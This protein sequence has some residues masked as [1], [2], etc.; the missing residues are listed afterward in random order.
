M[1]STKRIKEKKENRERL[2]L[3][4]ALLIALLSTVYW[5]AITT[6]AYRTFQ[7]GNND[8]A[9]YA[10]NFYFY[11]HYSSIPAPLQ[12]LVFS[13]HISPDMLIVMLLFYLHQSALTLLYI[14]V[15]LICLS[16]LLVFQISRKLIGYSSIALAFFLAFLINPG[17]LGILT[18]SFHVE[19]LLI[20]AYLL[21]FYFYMI[22]NRK[23]FIV[24]LLFL[25][26]TMEVAPILSLTLGLGLLAYEL[27][28]S[29]HKWSKI[30][31]KKRS[32]LIMLI[33]ISIIAGLLYYGAIKYLISSY[34]NS[35]LLPAP[36]QISSGSEISLLSNLHSVITNPIKLLIGNLSVYTN[37]V[38]FYILILSALIV[39]FGF[40][41]FTLKKWKV[42]LLLLLPWF[43]ALLTWHAS[44]HF[45]Y[46]GYQYYSYSLGATV[47]ASIIGIMSVSFKS[48]KKIIIPNFQRIIVILS[49]L[50]IAVLL[51]ESSLIIAPAPLN[52]LINYNNPQPLPLYNASQIDPLINMIPQNASLMVQDFI[53]PHL[54]ERKYIEYTW[55]IETNGSYFIPDYILV[56]Y[57][58]GTNISKNGTLDFFSR[59]IQ[60]YNYTLYARDGNARLYK[61][62]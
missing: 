44:L 51:L 48:A 15:I 4:I 7:D 19:F 10:Y 28:S 12:F 34:P 22:S 38:A 46:T 35:P 39:F 20:P 52:F 29:E 30:D 55:S 61:R 54:A 60:N 8:L 53:S 36:L 31:G 62:D 32:M 26:G 56:S 58:N 3:I 45:L 2:Y 11:I 6:H 17:V 57:T 27:S 21:V 9:L 33:A 40:G 59:S 50:I 1:P 14:Q 16:A 43:I 5:L 13:N 25:I 37:L 42:T 18:F 23:L 24:S 41:F 49:I 47:A